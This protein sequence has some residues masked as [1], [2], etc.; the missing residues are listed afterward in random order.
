[1]RNRNN[2]I[3]IL[4]RLYDK[5]IYEFPKPPEDMSNSELQH[6]ISR[7]REKYNET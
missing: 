7:I 3:A 5:H 6:A 2:K 4:L 1:M